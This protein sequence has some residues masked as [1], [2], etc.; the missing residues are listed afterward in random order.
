[1]TTTQLS[2]SFDENVIPAVT[3][4]RTEGLIE[5]SGVSKSYGAH[6]VLHEIDLT[7]NVRSPAPSP[8]SMNCGRSPRKNNS[9]FGFS[10]FDRNP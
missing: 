9:A 4:A 10:K 5:I 6:E 3:P 1:M 8:G 7:I 2:P